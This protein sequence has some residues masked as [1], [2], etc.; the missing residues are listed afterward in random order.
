M[1]A[2]AELRRRG[3]DAL[4]TGDPD[5]QRRFAADV[6]HA[7]HHTLVLAGAGWPEPLAVEYGVAR[8]RDCDPTSCPVTD[9][10]EPA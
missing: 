2:V 7:Y 8:A 5:T 3:A 9:P 1:N 10:K 4:A 6:I